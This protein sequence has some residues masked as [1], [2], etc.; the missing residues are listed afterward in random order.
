MDTV[1]TT[2]S[3]N[4]RS[5]LK[6]LLFPFRSYW[7]WALYQ[8]VMYFLNR[9]ISPLLDHLLIGSLSWVLNLE[10]AVQICNLMQWWQARFKLVNWITA[11]CLIQSVM[12]SVRKAFLVDF[13]SSITPNAPK[14]SNTAFPPH[15]KITKFLSSKLNVRTIFCQSLSTVPN[16]GYQCYVGYLGQ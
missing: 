1:D 8:H 16:I 13:L 9:L 12:K 4:H 15:W 2:T 5:P 3:L 6:L 11:F 10:Y 7:P 14:C